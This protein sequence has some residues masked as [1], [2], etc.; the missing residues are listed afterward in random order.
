MG[1]SRTAGAN[2]ALSAPICTD[3]LQIICVFTPI[4]IPA[5]SCDNKLFLWTSRLITLV[6]TCVGTLPCFLTKG[7]R[8]GRRRCWAKWVRFCIG[9]KRFCEF[10][11]PFDRRVI[12]HREYFNKMSHGGW[13]WESDVSINGDASPSALSREQWNGWGLWSK[14]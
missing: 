1:G 11:F 14:R 3:T 12:M 4:F 13:R 2:R 8:D 10:V 5:K 6:L 7:T 9:V